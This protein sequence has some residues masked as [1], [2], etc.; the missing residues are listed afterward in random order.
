MQND[1]PIPAGKITNAQSDPKASTGTADSAHKSSTD[2]VDSEHESGGFNPTPN[3]D[4]KAQSDSSGHSEQAGAFNT[5]AAFG[6]RAKSVRRT[7]RRD[8]SHRDSQRATLRRIISTPSPSPNRT[9]DS[10]RLFTEP[11]CTPSSRRGNSTR[12]P[13]KSSW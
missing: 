5:L 12:M 9:T 6:L 10:T 4:A 7:H 3:S 1:S 8:P 11:L 13:K 2:N